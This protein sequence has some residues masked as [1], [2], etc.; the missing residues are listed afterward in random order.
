MALFKPYKCTEDQLDSLPVVDGQLILT[1]DT[2]KIYMD[3][4]DVRKIYTPE[5]PDSTNIFV[6]EKQPE[7]AQD[8]DV[9]FILDKEIKGV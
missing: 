7:T 6:S 4:G 2:N 3:D 1:T 5:V 8:G 9:W